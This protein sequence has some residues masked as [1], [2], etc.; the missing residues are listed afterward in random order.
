MVND[1]NE[2]RNYFNAE[3][4]QLASDLQEN[5]KDTSKNAPDVK[6]EETTPENTTNDS[7]NAWMASL[8]RFKDGTLKK[9]L[10][11]VNL[12]IQNDKTF[13]GKIKYN[14]DTETIEFVKP[15]KFPK[16]ENVFIQDIQKGMVDDDVIDSISSYLSGNK[17]Y[18][19]DVKDAD[20]YS[21]LSVAARANQYDPL[22]DYFD[23]LKWDGKDRIGHVLTDF[24]GAASSKAD[25]LALT[26]WLECAVAKV[27]NK[28]VKVDEVLDLVGG[29][30]VGKSSFFR[31]IAP[32]DMYTQT[33]DT[34]TRKD[35]LMK[36]TNALIVNDDE[37]KASENSS[38]AVLKNFITLDKVQYRPP[39]A[40]R[41]KNFHKSF[42]ICRTGNDIQHLADKTGDRR[43]MSI[44]CGVVEKKKDKDGHE[45]DINNPEQFTQ[46]YVDELWAQA[47]HL[48]DEAGGSIRLTEEQYKILEEGRQD[49]MKTT[50]LE[51]VVNEIIENE[52]S[53][54]NFVSTS[55]MITLL[56]HKMQR[57]VTNP[58]LA[59]VR[60][61]MSND[62]KSPWLAGARAYVNG[63]H[64]HGFKRVN[65]IKIDPNGKT[66]DEYIDDDLHADAIL[67]SRVMYRYDP[68][69]SDIVGENKDA[70]AYTR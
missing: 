19:I 5:T 65:P 70:T 26:H 9:K 52:L 57:R 18:G 37:M 46:A 40:H 25:V 12:I 39:Y 38:F 8:E 62:K 11:N 31:V 32:L 1:I 34:F 63:K 43:F 30:G 56:N 22:V 44:K 45:Y 28:D 55:Q 42:V 69:R 61:Y 51:D 21:A 41:T 3:N 16:L 7:G 53:N 14:L 36:M 64:P 59:K 27:Y 54:T 24:L 2:L 67:D 23:G 29:Q 33:I 58:E 15:I 17:D 48:Y 10:N 47:K 20:I 6:Q 68:K 13:K 66:V 60:V 49:F 50:P 4:K 35:D